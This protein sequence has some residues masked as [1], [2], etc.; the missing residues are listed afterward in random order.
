MPAR[1]REAPS[2][3]ARLTYHHES[4]FRQVVWT[5]ALPGASPTPSPAC[6]TTAY[7]RYKIADPG[8]DRRDMTVTIDTL[9]PPKGCP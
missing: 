1:S 4:R 5:L 8:R 3:P 9:Q 6:G 7:R 2:A